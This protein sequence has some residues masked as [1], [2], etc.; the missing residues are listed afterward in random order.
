MNNLVNRVIWLISRTDLFIKNSS[1][2][3]NLFYI[4]LKRRSI[5]LLSWNNMNNPYIK[6][7][8]KNKR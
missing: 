4:R 7:L 5:W 1:C 8:D 2:M 3:L 6:H